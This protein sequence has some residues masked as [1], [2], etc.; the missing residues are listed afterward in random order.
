MHALEVQLSQAMQ[1]EVERELA[2]K[3]RMVRFFGKTGG[4]VRAASY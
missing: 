2:T 1:G 4:G 3:Y